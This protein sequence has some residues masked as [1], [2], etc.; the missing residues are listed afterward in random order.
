MRNQHEHVAEASFEA[1][2]GKLDRPS[3]A[4]VTVNCVVL[5][6]FFAYSYITFSRNRID[7]ASTH[8]ITLAHSLAR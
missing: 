7:A 8:P 2:S 4:V 1:G 6:A 3:L 5:T